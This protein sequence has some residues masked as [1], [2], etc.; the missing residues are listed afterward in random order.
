MGTDGVHGLMLP[1]V[2]RTLLGG[3]PDRHGS[4]SKATSEAIELDN[5]IRNR[6]FGDGLVPTPWHTYLRR[7][8]A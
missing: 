5:P 1:A 6:G 4:T 2:Y 8:C 3:Q 7:V